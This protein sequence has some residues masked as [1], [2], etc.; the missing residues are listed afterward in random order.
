MYIKSLEFNNYKVYKKQKFDFLDQESE[1]NNLINIFI[2]DNGSG[3]SAVLDGI[4]K[5][6]SW[7]P[8]RLISVNKNTSNLITSDEISNGESSASIKIKVVDLKIEYKFKKEFEDEID[9]EDNG[10]TV[11]GFE[12]I[13]L[14]SG[15]HKINE[16]K[17][18]NLEWETARTRAGRV[19]EF[20]SNYK[21]L[22]SYSSDLRSII[23]EATSFSLPTLIYY[24]AERNVVKSNQVNRIQNN[25][26]IIEYR[27]SLNGTSNFRQFF[28]WFEELENIEN[29]RFRKVVTQ[30]IEDHAQLSDGVI[31]DF[32]EDIRLKVV[33]SAVS[34]FL[35]N[36]T[37]IR[38]D[39]E[40]SERFKVKKDNQEFTF[41]QL[42]QGEKNLLSLV[43][44]IARTLCIMNPESD[45]P[46]SCPGIVLIDEI[47]LH[48]HPKWQ[49]DIIGKLQ[50]T[51]KNCQFFLTTH[52]PLVL[53]SANKAN[54][55]RV[56]SGKCEKLEFNL[57]GES[58]SHLLKTTMGTPER[59]R[60]VDL[61]INDIYASLDENDFSAARNF[62]ENLEQRINRES[63][64]ISQLASR[65]SM[66]EFF[67]KNAQKNN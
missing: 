21:Q 64:I 52:S 4:A 63:S 22:N 9:E 50:S 34:S 62:L 3:K 28:G 38:I 55:F 53:S 12:N 67:S 17:I 35:N 30:H 47:D 49:A 59:D 36:I 32:S 31:F 19:R 33:R 5:S 23:G 18:K 1:K 8:A 2:G 46:L 57:F 45:D 20:S 27:D 15:I 51:F 6:L 7:L 39:R 40:S 60:S 13:K 48:L 11:I 14:E 58:V 61:L 37:E 44:D 42:S 56:D 25:N 26:P 54:V 16:Y 43:G 41:G 65:I 24:G 10:Q 29:Q 66:E